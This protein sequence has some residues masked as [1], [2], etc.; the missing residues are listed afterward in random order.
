MKYQAYKYST[1]N[2]QYPFNAQ[3]TNIQFNFKLI[4]VILILDVE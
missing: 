1:F 4:M 2:A 3:W